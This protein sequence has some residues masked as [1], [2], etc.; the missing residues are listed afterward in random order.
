MTLD[1]SRIKAICID[2]DGTLRETDDYY[3]NRVQKL[4]RPFQAIIPGRDTRK[5]ARWLIMRG[6][7]PANYIIT[8][9]DMLGIDDE[10]SALVSRF[11][12]SQSRENLSKYHMVAGTELMLSELSKQYPLAVVTSRG[13]RKT[14]TFLEKFEL[15]NYFA[16]IV[17]AVTAPRTK[18]HPAPII[19]A[20]QKMNVKTDECLMVGDTAYDVIAGNRAGAQTVGVLSGFGEQKEL[21]AAGADVIL[22]SVVQLPEALKIRS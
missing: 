8:I 22:A 6:E 16:C 4:I 1:L 5:F 17:T 11:T 7:R 20:A 18:P 19:W 3:V 10:I 13:Q 15:V 14:M 12:S 9:P 21:E 2:V